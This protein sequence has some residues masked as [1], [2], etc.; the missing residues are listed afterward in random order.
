MA[1]STTSRTPLDS[2]KR[3]R[4]RSRTLLRAVMV[5][6]VGAVVLLAG[7]LI[8]L[9]LARS[10]ALPGV[11]VGDVALGGLSDAQITQ[12]LQALAQRKEGADVVAQRD[13]QRYAVPASELGYR[14]DVEA[15]VARVLHRGRQ[16]NPVTALRDHLQAFR[17]DIDVAAVE[18]IDDAALDDWTQAAADELELPPTE[19]GLAFEGAEVS[20]VRPEP[21]ATIDQ[22]HLAEQ[23]RRLMVAGAG[24]TIEVRTEP[25]EPTT[26][27]ESVDEVLAL[28]ERALAGDVTFRRRDQRATLTPEDIAGVLRTRVVDDE[29]QLRVNPKALR[30]TLGEDTIAAFETEPRSAGFDISGGSIELVE[31][32]DGF[33]YNPRKAARQLL[34]VATGDGRRTAT[35]NGDIEEAELD[36]AEAKKLEIVEKVSEFTTHHACCE[37]RVTNIHRIADIVDD[38]VIKPGETFSLNGFVGERTEAKGFAPGGAIFEGEFVEQIGGG[39]SQFTTTT[40][41]AAYFGGYE[42]VEHKAH[43]YYIS[44][45][46]VGREATLDY[47]SVDL[48]IKNNSPSGMVL[49]TSYTDESI[50]VAVYGKKWVKVDTVTGERRN[51]KQPETVYKENN[52]LAKGESRVIQEAG[53]P[54]FDITVT[55]ILKF[56]DG[57]VV[58]E[59]VTTTYL[60]QPK[61]IERNT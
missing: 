37:S 40:Y 43:S 34:A 20:A 58:R 3:S 44:R 16:G 42:I 21:G 53:A 39:V 33:T 57:R 4:S 45:Y 25:V 22:D 35:L 24:G 55:R 7:S 36:T 9:R 17:G 60:P 18:A 50:T 10:G 12:R 8:G 1:T 6:V 32:Y 5:L 19:G 52:D 38:V 28:A 2:P 54:G 23:A 29:L 27:S 48:K 26:T 49:S 47:P 13:T 61:I 30:A 56:P 59:P 41:N 46:P 11:H 51:I 31:G 14:M 15:T